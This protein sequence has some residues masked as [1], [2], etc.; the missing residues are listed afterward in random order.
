MLWSPAHLPAI[1]GRPPRPR[2]DG[3]RI[4]CHDEK[5]D[6]RNTSQ[7]FPL[8]LP[9]TAPSPLEPVPQKFFRIS[10]TIFLA[11]PK[12]IMVLSLKNNSFSTPA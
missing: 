8:R 3:G 1:R 2:A 5:A 4:V 12:S 7:P 6:P 11:S 10:S 9:R